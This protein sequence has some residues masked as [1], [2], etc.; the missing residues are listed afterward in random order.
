M[1]KLLG[2]VRLSTDVQAEAAAANK[3]K[4][5]VLIIIP[6]LSSGPL[7]RWRLALFRNRFDF[8]PAKLRPLMPS[9]WFSMACA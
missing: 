6:D 4:A 3:I 9:A 1:L 7:N 8:D 5:A 2:V